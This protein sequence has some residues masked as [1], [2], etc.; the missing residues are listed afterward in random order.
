MLQLLKNIA[1]FLL[2]V[3]GY[4]SDQKK[5]NQGKMEQQNADLQSTIKA[6]IQAAE[7]KAAVD[8]LSPEQL[9]S[10]FDKQ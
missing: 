4:V 9:R 8:G 7:D 3:F 1:V 5:I 6:G 2:G 10:E